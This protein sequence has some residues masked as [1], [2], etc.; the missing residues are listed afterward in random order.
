MPEELEKA[1]A[2]VERIQN[3]IDM[4]DDQLEELLGDGGHGM[5]GHTPA[6]QQLDRAQVQTDKVDIL[7]VKLGETLKRVDDTG[8]G[9]DPRVI[10]G[11]IGIG[12]QGIL[13]QLVKAKAE[14]NKAQAQIDKL[15]KGDSE[16]RPEES[17]AGGFTKIDSKRL[18]KS[19]EPK[20]RKAQPYR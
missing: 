2:E 13:K 11:Q 19:Q 10:H 5:G 16:Q 8:P 14:T 15:R 18:C 3:Q 6:K 20:H 12:I 4:L 7:A 1:Y 17:A 9:F